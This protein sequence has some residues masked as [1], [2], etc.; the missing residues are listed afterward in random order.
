MSTIASIHGREILD[1]RGNPTVE[2]EVTLDSGI[3]ERAAVPSGASTG[4]REALEMRDGENRFNGKGVLKAVKHVNEQIAEALVGEDCLQQVR[5]DT[6]LLDLDGTES[7]THLGANAML[8]VSMACA[9]LSGVNQHAPAVALMGVPR[10]IF[11]IA[12]RLGTQGIAAGQLPLIKI[13]RSI[14][15]HLA[16]A[17]FRSHDSARDLPFLCQI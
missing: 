7:K 14:R 11:Q 2:V 9:Q 15:L 13:Q 10:P 8:G 5:I 16:Q 6:T 1:S 17:D 3:C 12:Q 4:S